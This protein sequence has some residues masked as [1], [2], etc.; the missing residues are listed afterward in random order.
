MQFLLKKGALVD[1]SGTQ[2]WTPLAGACGKGITDLLT[3]IV[4]KAER[5]VSFS[6]IG[7][8]EVVQYLLFKNAN[9]H[10]KSEDQFTPLYSAARA[11]TKGIV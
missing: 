1:D 9:V 4:L 7:H 2:N 6:T 10:V 11:G 5:L 8:L 3:I